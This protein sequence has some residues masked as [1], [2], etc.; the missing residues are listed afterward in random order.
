MSID[1]DDVKFTL[2]LAMPLLL[3]VVWI[4]YLIFFSC[5]T[6]SVCGEKRHE[7]E[8]NCIHGENNVRFNVCD[9]CVYEEFKGR[10]K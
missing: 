6:C 5:G 2:V 4:V 9:Q 1:M 3:C 8:I 7:Y 10:L